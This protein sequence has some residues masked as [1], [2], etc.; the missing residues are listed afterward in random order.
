MFMPTCPNCSYTLVLL[1]Q[2]NKYKCALCSR[3][4]SQKEIDDKEFRGW[5]KRQRELAKEE[6]KQKK[7]RATRVKQTKEEKAGKSKEWR[8]KNKEKILQYKYNYRKRHKEK[9]ALE[10]Q[11]YRQ[12]HKE[13]IMLNDRLASWRRRQKGL[14]IQQRDNL[15][16]NKIELISETF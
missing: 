6:L 14:A 7:Q 11:R 8:T 4:Y 5:N 9:Y 12:K 15:S 1:Q 16:Q 2:R 10:M 13:E 3:L